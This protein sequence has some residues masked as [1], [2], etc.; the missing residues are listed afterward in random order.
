MMPVIGGIDV[1]IL[2]LSIIIAIDFIKIYQMERRF[3]E[4]L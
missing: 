4:E 2:L 3:Q 1:D